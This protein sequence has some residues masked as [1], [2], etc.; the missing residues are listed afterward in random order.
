MQKIVDVSTAF[1]RAVNREISANAVH[2]N[3]TVPVGS[4][5]DSSHIVR[6]RLAFLPA[7]Q[8][9]LN[10]SGTIKPTIRSPTSNQYFHS[11][12]Q[13]AI[14]IAISSGGKDHQSVSVTN[15]H[16]SV[17]NSEPQAKNSYNI[18]RKS[19]IGLLAGNTSSVASLRNI[20]NH[21]VVKHSTFAPYHRLIASNLE[22]I[23][24]NN[25]R[26]T[27]GVNVSDENINQS[28]L[29]VNHGS[30]SCNVLNNNKTHTLAK[31]EEW[32]QPICRKLLSMGKDKSSLT[33]KQLNRINLQIKQFD[34][35][36]SSDILWYPLVHNKLY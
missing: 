29:G 31:F 19:N 3:I 17:S 26:I 23:T 2:H 30:S 32:G 13:G 28:N 7:A 33:Y 21:T 11:K 18:L 16:I 34:L 6:P 5:W 15:Q 24:A 25:S 4:N 14:A 27:K 35:H 12:P 36:V 8:A 22:M 20:T 1:S 10:T 9:T